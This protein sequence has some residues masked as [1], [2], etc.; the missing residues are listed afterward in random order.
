MDSE[1]RPVCANCFYMIEGKYF[2]TCDTI[3]GIIPKGCADNLTCAS[4]C[5]SQPNFVPKGCDDPEGYKRRVYGD[6]YYKLLSPEELKESMDAAEI[7]LCHIAKRK[8]EY[9]KG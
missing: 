8:S 5:H 3:R 1:F 4:N 6:R 9:G 2:N 7:F